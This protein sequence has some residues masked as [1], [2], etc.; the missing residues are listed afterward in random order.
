VN[1][2]TLWIVFNLFVATML[3]LDLFVF[4]R[5]AR[6]P[7]I[8]E[9]IAWSALWIALA[10]G[11][12]GILYFWQ[13][14]AATF[15]FATGYLIE[16]SLSA[17]NLFVFILI[18]AHFRVPPDYQH[19]VL[20]WGVIGALVMRAAFIFLG[21]GL[22]TR[23]EWVIYIFGAFLV[24]TGFRLLR[25]HGVNMDLDNNWALRSLRRLIP[26]T[27]DYE[28]DKFFVSKP[29]LSATPLFA[30]LLI[31]ELTDLLFATDS[32]PAILAITY[33]TFIIYSSNVFA[34]L[35][36]RSMYF[37]LSHMMRTFRYLH[38]GLSLILIFIGAKMLASHYVP[39]ST[40]LAL[41]VVAVILVGSVIASKL[42]PEEA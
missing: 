33:K 35:G 38:Y 8:G 7:K 23:F 41:G 24:F 15:E 22:I 40:V 5:R 25:G 12:A 36:L 1:Q 21:V 18:F 4:N 42:I 14:R 17:D 11:F 13:G 3:V 20:F 19:K 39:I 30:V 37:A 34:I 28:G 27:A 29:K 16:L 2:S 32:I 31:V 6:S 26:V 10:V 9:A